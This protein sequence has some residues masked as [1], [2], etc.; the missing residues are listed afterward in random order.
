MLSKFPHLNACTIIYFQTRQPTAKQETSSKTVI[1]SHYPVKLYPLV[2][3]KGT[4]KGHELFA[5]SYNSEQRMKESWQLNGGNTAIHFFWSKLYWDRSS[6]RAIGMSC[7]ALARE[8][9]SFALN[10]CRDLHYIWKSLVI[11]NCFAL[12]HC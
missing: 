8:M 7:L 4:L 10:I 6:E 11:S 5:V 9:L 2:G 3:C 12:K 1:I